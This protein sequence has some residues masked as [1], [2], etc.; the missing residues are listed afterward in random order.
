MP[1]EIIE[2]TDALTELVHIRVSPVYEMLVS[3]HTL[4]AGRRHLAW[5]AKA[6]AMLGASFMAELEAIYGPYQDGVVLFEYPVDY[7]DHQDV[8][9]FIDYVRAMD[10]ATFIFYLIGR[11]I[12]RDE[13]KR[14]K[15]DPEFVG[16]SLIEYC[17]SSSH[18]PYSYVSVMKT[19]LQDVPAFQRRLTDLWE[20][21]WTGFFQEQVPALEGHWA[22]G[23][24]DK[25]YL[26]AR[27]GGN[28]LYEF[29][30]GKQALPGNLPAD[31]PI[32]EITC[33]P[34]YFVSSACYLFFGYGNVTI[35]FNSEATLARRSE[36]EQRKDQALLVTKA[37]SDNTRLEILKLIVERDGHMHG[38]KIAE[39]L[40]LSPSSISRQLAQLRDSGL[41]VE[42]R[43]DDQTVTY[44]LVKEAISTLA[45]KILDYLYS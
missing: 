28:A 16:Q 44:R 27:E 45:D 43:H 6:R 33:V 25:E 13:L 18:P 36:I 32:T 5:A 23:L 35:L 22:Q 42:E 12:P 30:T 38:K 15:L 19:M 20:R 26:L 37:L 4:V 24:A 10:P 17:E 40:D 2:T 31:Q 41:V 29:I 11:V 9:G 39:K 14:S 8:T 3:L 1:V 34:V 7:Q 21:Y